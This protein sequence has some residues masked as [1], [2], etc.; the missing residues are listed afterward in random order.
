MKA[1]RCRAAI[2]LAAACVALSAAP[3]SAGATITPIVECISERSASPGIYDVYFGYVNDGAQE[4]IAFGDEN[5]V[6]P[7]LGFQGQ[8]TVFNSGSYPRVFRGIYNSEAFT[9]ISW[10]L[11]GQQAIASKDGIDSPPTAPTPLCASGA[12]GPAS[13][14][15]ATSARL[16][17]TVK[18][19]GVAT[20]YNFDYGET[21][22]Y[23]SSTPPQVLTTASEAPVSEPIFGLK[24]NTTYHYRLVAQGQE[25]TVGEDRTFTTPAAPLPPP[26]DLAL[27]RS[28]ASKTTVGRRAR[29]ALSVANVG[30]AS[31][32]GVELA[33]ALPGGIRLVSAAAPGGACEGARTVRCRVG[34]L[35]AGGAATVSVVL[36]AKRRGRF[37]YSATAGAD[38]TEARAAD[39]L[40]VATLRARPR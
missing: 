34:A 23:G 8:P 27:S 19:G 4:S 21:I 28:G 36:K 35:P 9:A 5:Q 33:L 22:A 32:T 39:N 3:S 31:A 13:D 14:L 11:A 16:N 26:A 38:Q 30:P 24:P 29:I 17:G 40:L 7:G 10:V 25:N 18:P 37:T 2:S 12:T 20:A 1:A 15:T 6:V